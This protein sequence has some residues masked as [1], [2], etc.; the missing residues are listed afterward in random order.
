MTSDMKAS[1]ALRIEL[2]KH[3]EV[4]SRDLDTVLTLAGAAADGDQVHAIERAKA[5]M[6]ATPGLVVSLAETLAALMAMIEVQEK[7]SGPAPANLQ[8]IVGRGLAALEA[9]GGR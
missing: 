8:A 2:L 5:I 9:I 4:V 1:S 6:K 7:L 3:L